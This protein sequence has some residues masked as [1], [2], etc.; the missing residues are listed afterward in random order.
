MYGKAI[1]DSHRYFKD[2][3]SYYESYIQYLKEML[4]EEVRK[5][6]FSL[7]PSRMKSIYVT[8]SYEGASMYKKEY[9]KKYIYEVELENP[10]KAITVDM[11]WMDLS[12]FQSYD[13]VKEMARNYYSG[14]SI[15]GSVHWGI[16]EDERENHMKLESFWET[17]Y[18][19]KVVVKRYIY[20]SGGL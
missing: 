8:D 14:K 13:T 10:N 11:R 17:L 12:T 5:A 4:F 3:V 20:K 9:E 15:D 7:L 19:G 1:R 2:N 18:D 16:Y 6:E